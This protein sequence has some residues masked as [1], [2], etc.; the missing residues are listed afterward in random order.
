MVIFLVLKDIYKKKQML[1]SI[2]IIVF[3][4]GEFLKTNKRFGLVLR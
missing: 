4:N 3:K 2:S 1:Q